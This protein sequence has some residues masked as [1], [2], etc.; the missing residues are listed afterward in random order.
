MVNWRDKI[1]RVCRVKGLRGEEGS[2]L[3]EMALCSAILL[4]MT[5]GII[6]MSFGLYTFHYVSEAAREGSRYAMVRGST[7]C[8][9]TPNLVNCKA[10]AAEI[11][12][13]VQSLGNPG[14]TVNTIWL[15]ATTSGTPP[16]TTWAACANTCNSPGNAVQ[17]NVVYLAF[18]IDVPFWKK[19]SVNIG[20]T[21]QM[22]IA[23]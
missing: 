5:F 23:Q 14:V 13:Y 4:G 18:P 1:R 2:S 10:T 19:T 17:V 16:T 9:N 3:V 21:S 11:Q 22:V 8:T 15:K 20:S 7:S 6:E 12:T